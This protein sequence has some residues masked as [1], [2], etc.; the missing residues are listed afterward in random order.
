M[1]ANSRDTSFDIGHPAP[2]R[3]RVRNFVLF[4]GLAAAAFAWSVEL[5]ATASLGGAACVTGD[6][7]KFGFTSAG[8]ATVTLTVVNLVALLVAF[9]ALAISWRNMK[10]ASVLEG[11]HVTGD[12][13]VLDSGEG[14]T[15]FISVW[16]IFASVL[17]IIAIGFNTIAVFWSGL[18]GA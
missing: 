11:R 9:G 3:G 7:P 1:A 14:R 8:W 18:C 10:R 4:F 15:R 16:G 12:G 5:A 13:G 6:G 17:F 2:D